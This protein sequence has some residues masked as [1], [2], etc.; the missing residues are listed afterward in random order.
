[1]KPEPRSTPSPLSKRMKSRSLSLLPL[2]VVASL[3][4]TLGWLAGTGALRAGNQ[5]SAPAN[6]AAAKQSGEPK[7]LFYQSAM[8]PWIKSDQPGKCTICGME[9]TPVF[10]GDAGFDAQPGMVKLSSN[11]VSILGVASTE[12]DLGPL[13]RS[14]RVAGTVEE[15]ETRHRFI[16]AYVGGRIEDLHV[17]FVGT[18]V[19]AGQPLARLF[20]PMLLEAERQF[21]ALTQGPELGPD[22]SWWGSVTNGVGDHILLRESAAERLR[23]LGLTPE[24]IAALPGKSATNHFTEILAPVSGTVVNRFVYAGQTV[25]EGEKLFEIADFSTLW[26]RFDA[27]EQDLPWLRVGLEVEVTTPSLPGQVLKAPI[28]FIDPTLDDKTR[29]AKVRVEL[30]NP[31]TR[32]AEAPAGQRLLR[33]RLYAEGR[34][35]VEHPNVPRIPRTAVLS[36]D[37]QPVIYLDHTGGAYERRTIRLGR[38]GDTHYEVLEG[39]RVGERVVTAGNLLIDAQA[40]LNLAVHGPPPTD[41]AQTPSPANAPTFPPLEPDQENAL[42]AFLSAV[43]R[44]RVGLAADDLAGFNAAVPNLNSA[45]EGLARIFPSTENAPGSSVASRLA[46]FRLSSATDLRSARKAFHPLSAATVDAVRGLRTAGGPQA[47]RELRLY[48]CPMTAEAFDGAPA[49]ALWFQFGPPLKNP[50]FGEE[51]LDCGTE[52]KP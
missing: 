13:V 18:E 28:R 39:A 34:V 14:L 40:Q 38:T 30:P 42:T 9:L 43:D 29:S 3:A 11:S 25:M 5:T 1:M 36:P 32:K 24:Q 15:D 37:G 19:Q 26:F 35:R 6:A 33:Q 4:G 10:E 20:S 48:Q 41:S 52:V 16:S 23:Q 27:Y 47:F 31:L 17:N 44:L 22:P 21:L 8:H 2:V 50:W 46:G 49:R 51:M 7:V 45:A 12:I